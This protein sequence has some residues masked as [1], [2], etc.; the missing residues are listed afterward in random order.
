[1]IV[2]GIIRGDS[3]ADVQSVVPPSMLPHSVLVQSSLKSR[4]RMSPPGHVKKKKKKNGMTINGSLKSMKR[5]RARRAKG[6]DLSQKESPRVRV[7]QDRLLQ[8]LHSLHR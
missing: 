4:M 1:M 8:G 6:K 2:Q 7:P 3:Q 5:L